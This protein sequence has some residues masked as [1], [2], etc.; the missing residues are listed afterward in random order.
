VVERS[1]DRGEHIEQLLQDAVD[2]R[3]PA[4]D[5]H[6]LVVPLERRT[7]SPFTP[8]RIVCS[9]CALVRDHRGKMI[10][11][12]DHGK[13]PWFALPLW[14]TASTPWGAVWAYN[15]EHQEQLRAF[16]AA[17]LRER[18]ATGGWRSKLPAWMKDGRHRAAI[19][20]AI[21]AMGRPAG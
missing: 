3:C 5:A 13:D 16:I 17:D 2:V 14:R 18:T 4:C 20:K 11:I 8:R 19:L 9:S 10:T 12:H 6:A 1:L 15:A 7:R 21:D